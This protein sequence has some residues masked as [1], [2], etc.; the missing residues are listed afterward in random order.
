M[1]VSQKMVGLGCA[2][3]APQNH[4]G[5][6]AQERLDYAIECETQR[7]HRT[8]MPFCVLVISAG[9]AA[10]RKRLH[11]I[12]RQRLRR[13]DQFGEIGQGQ[14]GILL[15]D[16][17]EAGARK[18]A[19]SLQQRH[20]NDSS[21]SCQTYAL[22]AS[23][24]KV[25]GELELRELMERGENVA[26]DLEQQFIR[27]LPRWKRTLDIVGSMAGILLTWPVVLLAAIAIKL[28]SRGP[29]FFL[30]W[31]DG[32]GGQPFRMWKLRTMVE[33]AEVEQGDLR[34]RS[35]QDGPA[36]KMR[37]DPRVTRVG[38]L[39]RAL[40]IDEFPQFINVLRGEMSLVGPRPL[41]CHESELCEPWQRRRLEVTPGLTCTWQIKGRSLV[42]FD[43]WVRMDLQYIQNRSLGND[44]KLLLLTPFAMLL[45]R[46]C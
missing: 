35:E 19:E 25:S 41:P 24:Q 43:E 15:P 17:D 9:T 26:F 36:F 14:L 27:P 34:T 40:S 18:V 11:A 23:D 38:K 21:W 2:V 29:V 30:Q 42:S 31:R 32:L 33:G 37:I 3:K 7:A 10:T 28:T 39:L 8:G 12:C 13:I 46:G 22:A 20:A 16:T 6:H 45:R 44:L 5:P 1:A 4:N